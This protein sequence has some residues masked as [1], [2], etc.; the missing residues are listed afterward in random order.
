MS[1][2]LSEGERVEYI[3][4]GQTMNR[5]FSEYRTRS[6]EE[7]WASFSAIADFFEERRQRTLGNIVNIAVGVVGGVIGAVIGSVATF[8]LSR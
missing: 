3:G 4:D 8:L 2:C 5:F 6:T 1:D 7:R